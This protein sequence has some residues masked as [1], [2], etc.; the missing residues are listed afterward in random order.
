[1][2]KRVSILITNYNKESYVKECINSCLSQEYKNLEIIIVDNNSTDKSFEIINNFNNKIKI[3]VKKRISSIGAENQLDSLIYAFK[4]SSGD[5]IC[6]LDSD[7]FFMPKKIKVIEKMFSEN[8]NLKILFDIPRIVKKNKIEPIKIK[9][10]INKHIWPTTIPTSGISLTR[11]FFDECLEIDLFKDFPNLEID[12]KL[13]SFSLK[14][15]NKNF[16][17]DDYLTF[18]RVVNNGIMANTKKFSFQWWTRRNQAHE[19]MER[20]YKK[21]NINYKK[22]YDYFLTKIINNLLN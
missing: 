11:D 5:L 16:I 15:P 19:F 18:Y 1:M 9:N 12:F 4:I 6:L 3:V 14:I 17:I 2:K 10:K 20:I 22:N 13:T 21:N 7:D 8:E